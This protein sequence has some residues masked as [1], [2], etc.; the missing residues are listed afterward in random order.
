MLSVFVLSAELR[1][2][3]CQ[4]TECNSVYQYAKYQLY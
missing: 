2:A 1:Y 3:E 4:C